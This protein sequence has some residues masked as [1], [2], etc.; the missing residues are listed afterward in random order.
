MYNKFTKEKAMKAQRRKRGMAL[1]LTSALD[2]GGWSMPRPGSF[3]SGKKT[4]YPLYWRLGGTQGQ[5]GWVQKI[6]PPT[7]IRTWTAQPIASRYTDYDIL[8]HVICIIYN[9]T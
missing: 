7:G 1:S 3:T 8:T 4:W 6:S 5:S 2:G 9:I